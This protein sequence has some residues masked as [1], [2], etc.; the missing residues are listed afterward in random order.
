MG[1]ERLP[2]NLRK[3][4]PVPNGIPMRL[5]QQPIL[6]KDRR[7][8]HDIYIHYDICHR[9]DHRA[10]AQIPPRHQ[11]APATATA[12]NPV[13]AVVVIP[14]RKGRSY[15]PSMSATPTDLRLAS[16]VLL[17]RDTANPGAGLE[18][19]ME[20]RH[21]DSGFVGGAYVFPGGRVDPEDAIDAAHCADDE[22]SAGRR[23]GLEQGALA[24]LVA[25]IRECFEEAGV[26]LAYSRSGSILDFGDPAVEDRFKILRDRLNAGTISIQQI[27]KLEGLR[28]ATDRIAYWSHWITPLGEPRR[29]DTRFFVAHAPEGQTAGH[30]D[31]ELTSSA[32]VTPKDAIDRAI[33]REWMIIFPT[34]MNLRD[35]SRHASAEAAVAWAGRQ[36]LPLR[37]NQPRILI[38]RVVLPGDAG[39]DEAEPD[40]LK[41]DPKILARTFSLS[42][43]RR[44]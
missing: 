30:D 3:T 42:A 17:L 35:L 34:L 9:Q 28:L 20:K 16:T 26:L 21:V 41:I 4:L 18:V 8:T 36:P 29:Y 44:A 7:A 23:L 22:T 43:E 1:H 38:D 11:D 5:F 31:W 15:L 6:H 13:A 32:W 37:A 14:T 19:F 27:A 39:Y 12:V 10:W 24:H 25:A 40:L 2:N 33:R